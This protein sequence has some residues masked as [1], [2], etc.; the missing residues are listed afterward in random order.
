MPT[1]RPG[2]R[3]S[4]KQRLNGPYRHGLKWRVYVTRKGIRTYETF[5]SKG[6]AEA[7]MAEATASLVEVSAGLL[8]RVTSAPSTMDGWVYAISLDPL[9]NA[10]RIKV[11]FTVAP[12][13]RI[14]QFR[15]ANP[16]AVIVGLWEAN[17][18]NEDRAHDALSGRVGISEVFTVRNLTSALSDIDRAIGRRV[19]PLAESDKTIGPRRVTKA[20]ATATQQA[21]VPNGNPAIADLVIADVRARQD[22]GQ[23]RYGVDLQA[24]NG[25]DAL[26][27]AYQEAI[28]LAM[29][30][31][32]AIEE[33]D[34]K[35]ATETPK[36]GT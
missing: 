19:R 32:Q 10:T 29:Y 13:D 5:G 23:R 14:A 17:R 12:S 27:D 1:K 34:A 25:R 35:T 2:S 15:T 7:F 11:G 16:S 31:R 24:G 4:V 30:L 9:R 28:D 20:H 6:K 8:R 26:V 3:R 33:R 21:P 18:S 22:L 36:Q